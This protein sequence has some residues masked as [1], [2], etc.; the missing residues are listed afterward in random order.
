LFSPQDDG[1]RIG[2]IMS[3]SNEELASAIGLACAAGIA[4]MFSPT[5]DGG[6]LGVHVWVGSERD[7]TY[8]TSPEQFA[9]ILASVRDIAEARLAGAPG[10]SMKTLQRVSGRT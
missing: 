1:D 3:V 2:A 5:S 10:A 8:A 4:V 9:R 6:A 7:K